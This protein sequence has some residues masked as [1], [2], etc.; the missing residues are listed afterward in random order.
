MGRLLLSCLVIF[1]VILL[2]P[3]SLNAANWDAFSEVNNAD[4]ERP[5]SADYASIAL[6]EDVP[7]PSR[8]R[9]D[10]PPE[11]PKWIDVYNDIKKSPTGYFKPYQNVVVAVL[12]SPME[13]KTIAEHCKK[14]GWTF[15]VD[16]RPSSEL[17]I[18][19]IYLQATAKGQL[20]P[21][22]IDTR[23]NVTAAYDQA[24][25]QR[26]NALGW[27]EASK[28]PPAPA[29]APVPRIQY[30]SMPSM[31]M[32]FMDDGGMGASCGA[33]GGAACSGGGVMMA[34]PMMGGFFGGGGLFGGGGFRGSSCG[35][36][37]CN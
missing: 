14:N 37:G 1:G 31:G 30:V 7:Q 26:P 2:G 13:N 36:G 25:N 9:V 11:Y 8:T 35:A 22:G 6:D 29:V 27:L 10:S 33:G 23:G 20:Y 3:T 34:G 17:P 19:T 12:Q 24:D 15:C 4:S 21:T 32:P 16:D 5:E 18:G 28:A